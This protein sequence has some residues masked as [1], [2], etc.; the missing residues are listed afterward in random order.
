MIKKAIKAANSSC[1]IKPRAMLYVPQA[2]PPPI[3]PFDPPSFGWAAAIRP[4]L[5]PYASGTLIRA[6][7]GKFV[8]KKTYFS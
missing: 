6:A 1:E 3:A 8:N 2:I 4:S 5:P 7:G